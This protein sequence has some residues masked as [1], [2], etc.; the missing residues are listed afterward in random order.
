MDYKIEFKP[1]AL[2][3]GTTVLEV[4]LCGKPIAFLLPG[5]AGL[6][7]SFTVCSRHPI[8]TRK[9][10]GQAPRMAEF[11]ID[12]ATT[13]EIE[14]PAQ[15]VWKVDPVTNHQVLVPPP[16]PPS[17]PRLPLPKELEAFMDSVPGRAR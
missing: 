2:A 10:G 8:E 1:S 7:P 11:E 16:E 3:D 17:P 13:Y 6:R 4:V 9:L 15:P 5:V 12:T 14:K